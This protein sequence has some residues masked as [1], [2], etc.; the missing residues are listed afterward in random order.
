MINRRLLLLGL[1]GSF[2]A[3]SLETAEAFSSELS[4][5]SHDKSRPISDNQAIPDP[6]ALGLDKAD[7]AFSQRPQ[8]HYN[9]QRQTPPRAHTRRRSTRQWQHRRIQR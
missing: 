8:L 1:A 5:G 6:V 7:V 3:T 9:R 4:A 2:L